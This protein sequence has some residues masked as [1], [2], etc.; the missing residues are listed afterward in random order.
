MPA[1]TAAQPP[2]PEPIA[3]APPTLTQPRRPVPAS[4]PRPQRAKPKAAAPVRPAPAA[5]GP[6]P[7][8]G[9]P[10]ATAVAAGTGANSAGAGPVTAPRFDA[11]YLHNPAPA[12]PSLSRRQNEAGKVLLQ[13]KVSAQGLADAVTLE[14]SS[15]FPRLDAAAQEA[16]R[17][18]RFIPARWGT[19]TIAAAVL[20]P[21]VFRLDAAP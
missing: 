14:R 8:D 16:V 7:A 1:P 11:D 9:S 12:Y 15:G 20:V 17:R 3:P 2:V 18:W 4:P 6:S 5:P 10:A 19:E 21:I 13:V